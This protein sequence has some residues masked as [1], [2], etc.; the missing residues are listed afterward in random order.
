MLDL[1]T[2]S[3]D[4]RSLVGIRGEY[5]SVIEIDGM[6]FLPTDDEIRQASETI[7]ER[8]KSFFD[9][10]GRSVQIL[11]LCDPARTPSYINRHLQDLRSV[12]RAIRNDVE[13]ILE[14]RERLWSRH[15][16]FEATYLARGHCRPC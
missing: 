13:P 1:E 11:F 3:N 4:G 9:D 6:H 8:L 10:P 7:R 15:M 16:C 5:Q 12:S 2:E 14:E